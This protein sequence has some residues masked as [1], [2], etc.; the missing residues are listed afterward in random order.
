MAFSAAV[1]WFFSSKRQMNS[2]HQGL[3]FEEVVAALK[4]YLASTKPLF[5]LARVDNLV[6][7]SIK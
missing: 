7:R 5:A 1:K 2:S 6:K 4:D 3:S